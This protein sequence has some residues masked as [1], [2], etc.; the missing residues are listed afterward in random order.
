MPVAA[1]A[2]G[3]GLRELEQR[4]R[5]SVGLGEEAFTHGPV[6]AADDDR[7]EQRARVGAREPAEVQGGK[8]AE[9][10]KVFAAREHERDSVGAEAASDERERLRRLGVEPLCVIDDAEERLRGGRLGE[11]V[12]DGEP[13]KVPVRR[14]S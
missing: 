12:E 8:T 2:G 11:Q 7:V 4:E 13:D 6:E 5:V 9:L 10:C 3:E 1:S 14:L